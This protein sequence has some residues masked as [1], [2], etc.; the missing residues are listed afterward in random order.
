LSPLADALDGSAEDQELRSSVVFLAP[1]PCVTGAPVPKSSAN[2]A[3]APNA[4]CT[5]ADAAKPATPG[6]PH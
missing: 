1:K 3:I 2:P 4:K 5:L 6:T